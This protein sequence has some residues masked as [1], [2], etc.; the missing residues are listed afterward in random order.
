MNKF[1]LYVEALYWRKQWDDACPDVGMGPTMSML[2]AEIE[3]RVGPLES[4]E[5]RRQV[6]AAA[7]RREKGE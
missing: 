2:L 5:E 3:A 4:D 6:I 7:D 1:N